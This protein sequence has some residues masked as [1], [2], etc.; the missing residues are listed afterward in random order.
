MLRDEETAV[1]L[2]ETLANLDKASRALSHSLVKF[3]ETA[4]SFPT[5]VSKWNAVVD[6]FGRAAQT[7]QDALKE[8]KL[9]ALGIQEHPLMKGSIK[10]VREKNAGNSGSGRASSGSS[11]K[12]NSSSGGGD[13][14][15]KSLFPLFQKFKKNGNR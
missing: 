2:D 13:S 1:Q 12:K 8:Y 4:S 5:V 15:K 10:K 6:G 14:K 11:S 9:I 7:M 3:D